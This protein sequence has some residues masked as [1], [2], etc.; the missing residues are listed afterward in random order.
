MT[1]E[2][3]TQVIPMTDQPISSP[4]P[5]AEPRLPPSWFI[6]TFWKAHRIVYRLT[7]GRIGLWRPKAGKWGT[8]RLTTT[9]RR[10]GQQRV[11]I[12]GY[13]EDGP[14]LVTMAMNGWMEAEPA[15]WLNLQAHPEAVVELAGEQR[16]VLGR[17]AEGEERSRLWAKWAAIDKDLD[18][19]AAKR[20]GETAVVVLEPI[21][22]AA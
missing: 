11:A 4:Q 18:G 5:V 21:G 17:A 13:Y 8:L 9:G 10:S 1:I 20:P 14:N 15:W 2:V 22:R 6:R 19:Y 7:R 12:L 3:R 16:T